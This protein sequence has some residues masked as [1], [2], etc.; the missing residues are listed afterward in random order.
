[1]S[2]VNFGS[3]VV[4][5]DGECGGRPLSPHQ[6]TSAPAAIWTFADELLNGTDDEK[7]QDTM[8]A[9]EE[10]TEQTFLHKERI[11]ET[12]INHQFQSCEQAYFTCE[13]ENTYIGMNKQESRKAR[14][15]VEK[16]IHTGTYVISN[17]AVFY[18]EAFVGFPYVRKVTESYKKHYDLIVGNPEPTIDQCEYLFILEKDT[19]CDIWILIREEEVFCF[20]VHCNFCIICFCI[21]YFLKVI[22][23]LYDYIKHCIIS[24]YLGCFITPE[25]RC[26]LH[27]IYE[28]DRNIL[29]H[30]NESFEQYIKRIIKQIDGKKF[31]VAFNID[32]RYEIAYYTKNNKFDITSVNKLIDICVEYHLQC[33]PSTVVDKYRD[34]KE[35][36]RK[37]KDIR[38][39]HFHNLPELNRTVCNIFWRR[40][41]RLR[42]LINSI[43]LLM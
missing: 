23:F 24:L 18:K 7:Y 11:Y 37:I 12:E 40:C 30:N 16:Y 42:K 3:D 10:C 8:C 19:L 15:A 35:I 1:M 29:G 34:I 5:G 38:N 27:K 20:S 9:Q 2:V 32:E 31:R 25:L 22:K 41:N 21:M 6:I 4:R 36:S 14:G 43:K 13:E 33:V 26:I 28:R 17:I 39:E